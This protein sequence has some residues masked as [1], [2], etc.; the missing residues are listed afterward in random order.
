MGIETIKIENYKSIKKCYLNLSQLNALIGENGCGKTNILEAI[1]YFY[2]NLIAESIDNDIYDKNNIF[3]KTVKIG[4]QYDCTE[5]RKII[6]NKRKTQKEEDYYRKILKLINKNKLYLELIKTKN[7]PIQ[8]NIPLR[9]DREIIYHIFP[10][11]AI[12]TKHIQA[13]SWQYIWREIGDL[14]KIENKTIKEYQQLIVDIFE[15][16]QDKK[17]VKKLAE[18][19]KVL[20]NS[21]IQIKKY[22]PREYATALTKMYYSGEKFEI[23]EHSPNYFSE[24]TNSFNYINTLIYI[25]N[26]IKT[27]K[28]KFPT[29]IIDE[30]EIS[31]HHKYIDKIA[32]NI[33]DKSR[34]IQ[35]IL[36]THSA[37]L[38]KNILQE[39]NQISK[40]FNLKYKNQYTQCTEM[41]LLDQ[42][43]QKTFIQ[44]EQVNCYFSRMILMVEG[45]SELELLNNKY[46]KILFPILSNL[47]IIKVNKV[48]ENSLLPNKRNYRTPY[49]ILI[50]MDKTIVKQK[51]SNQFKKI[52]SGGYFIYDEKERFYY[53]EKRIQTYQKRKRIEKMLEK[54]QFHYTLPF[55]ACQDANF[56]AL[57]QYI[58]EYFLNYNIFVNE[59]TIEGMLINDENYD[60][61][62]KFYK[63]VLKKTK[64]I[65]ELEEYYDTL[66]ENKKINFLRLLVSGKTDYLLKLEELDKIYPQIKTLISKSKVSKTSGWITMWIE[67]YLLELLQIQYNQENKERKL[68]RELAKYTEFCQYDFLYHFRELFNLIKEISKRYSY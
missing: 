61:F 41:K 17:M 40:V 15:Q 36:A 45:E 55:Y 62:W 28:I 27:K 9:E 12:D 2:Y 26:A 34:K 56:Y 65:K 11:Y 21:E 8:W 58:K 53:G 48:I 64:D 47:D 5:L 20:K 16:E 7:K 42:Q 63:Q 50:D 66:N 14:I 10:I 23:A 54:C 49:L 51:D 38:L 13:E 6:V 67:Y 33:M 44:D 3:S 18:L 39:D 31:L 4:I 52:Q 1:K 35:F 30:P 24:G 37:R 29:I 46:I 25:V 19:E 60:K 43:R 68:K 22:T 59:T 32:D 57:K